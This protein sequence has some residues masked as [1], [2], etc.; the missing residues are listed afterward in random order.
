MRLLGRHVVT[1]VD[2]PLRPGRYEVS[3]DASGLSAGIYL[4]R[5]RMGDFSAVRQMTL[6]K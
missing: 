4:Y 2:E 1:L 3:F 5:V 6:L